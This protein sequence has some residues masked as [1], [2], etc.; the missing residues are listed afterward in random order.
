M[1]LKLD[2]YSIEVFKSKSIENFKTDS[3]DSNDSNNEK[4]YARKIR[5]IIVNTDNIATIQID[6]CYS[7]VYELESSTP[8]TLVQINLVKNNYQEGCFV[9]LDDIKFLWG[10]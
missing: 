2:D 1:F 10:K 7:K 3:N 8:I 5:T 6:E 4:I 9:K